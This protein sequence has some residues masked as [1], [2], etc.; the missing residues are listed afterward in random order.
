MRKLGTSVIKKQPVLRPA[1]KHAVRF[2]RP[3]GHQIINKDADV[4]F[5]APMI[6]GSAPLTF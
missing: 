6:R 1:C 5:V 2:I 4:P 3:F